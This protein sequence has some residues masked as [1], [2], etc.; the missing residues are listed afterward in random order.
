MLPSPNSK[1]ETNFHAGIQALMAQRIVAHQLG[2]EQPP[3]Q[4]KLPF[5]Q[6]RLR[7]RHLGAH[8]DDA[9]QSAQQHSHI[10]I[11]GFIKCT[12]WCAHTI[13]GAVH[14]TLHVLRR[15]YETLQWLRLAQQQCAGYGLDF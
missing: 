13:D 8:N 2:E 6:A 14:F 7:K 15:E 11:P 1:P 10:F 3:L 5:P 9:M 4:R 12:A